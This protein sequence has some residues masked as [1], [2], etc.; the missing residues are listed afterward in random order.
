MGRVA[1]VSRLVPQVIGF[2]VGVQIFAVTNLDQE[3]LEGLRGLGL[4]DDSPIHYGVEKF[5]R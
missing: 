4:G 1:V 2:D 5:D 3:N